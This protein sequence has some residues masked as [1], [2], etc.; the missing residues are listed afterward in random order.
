[1]H[2]LKFVMWLCGFCVDFYFL[3]S[4]ERLGTRLCCTDEC[5]SSLT[6]T[7]YE[8]IWVR[9][10]IWCIMVYIFYCLSMVKIHSRCY[11]GVCFEWQCKFTAEP[12]ITAQ[13][14][15]NSGVALAKAKLSHCTV[16]NWSALDAEGWAM[17]SANHRSGDASG[18][19]NRPI[20]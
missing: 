7:F 17:C 15:Q 19:I 11:P 9:D 1:M 6:L 18:A 4:H 20:N 8:N 2:L 10:E 13:N 16:Q 5:C 14:E 12:K 3:V